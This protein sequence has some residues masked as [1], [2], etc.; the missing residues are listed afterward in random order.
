MTG[1]GLVA[2]GKIFY[3]AML[4]KTSNSSYP[5]YRIWTITSAKN[6]YG[7]AACNTVK[8]AW[9]AVSL[10]AQKGEPTC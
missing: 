10:T 7:A 3:N 1:L 4:M 5:K 9:N 6:L 2:A 8:A